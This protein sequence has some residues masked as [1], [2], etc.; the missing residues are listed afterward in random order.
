MVELHAFQFSGKKS[1]RAYCGQ[2][3]ALIPESDQAK[4]RFATGISKPLR[5]LELLSHNHGH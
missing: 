4:P 3:R 1:K 5:E 2:Y